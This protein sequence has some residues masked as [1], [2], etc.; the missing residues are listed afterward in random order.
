MPILDQM[1]SIYFCVQMR[2]V[3][4][5][6]MVLVLRLKPIINIYIFKQEIPKVILE[7]FWLVFDY[8]LLP[9][10]LTQI[11]SN[12]LNWKQ[13]TTKLKGFGHIQIVCNL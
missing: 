8:K 5:E 6:K 1:R 2:S 12:K 13:E 4:G 10:K 7:F 9:K 3:R 11:G